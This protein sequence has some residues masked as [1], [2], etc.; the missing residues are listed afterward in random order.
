MTLPKAIVTPESMRR[1][2]QTLFKNGTRPPY[3][4]NGVPNYVAPNVIVGVVPGPNSYYVDENG[5]RLT[6]PDSTT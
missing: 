4:V 5:V 3:L 2:A 1:A 6:S